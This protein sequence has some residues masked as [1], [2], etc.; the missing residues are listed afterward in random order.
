VLAEG[1]EP[2]A[3][4]A[5]GLLD[6][7][8]GGRAGRAHAVGRRERRERAELVALEDAQPPLLEVRVAEQP[9]GGALGAVRGEACLPQCDKE[10]RGDH[11]R[12][13]YER[14]AEPAAARGVGGARGA[15]RGLERRQARRVAAAP[16][17]V[18]GE[19]VAVPH[20]AARAP[21]IVPLAGGR[22]ELL[23]EA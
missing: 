21:A 8:A 17:L 10:H 9:F 2:G 4:G 11:D 12:A 22:A 18:L 13:R 5:G 19:R 23:L 20:E 3:G 16:E 6:Q 14:V 1:D 15:E 7:E